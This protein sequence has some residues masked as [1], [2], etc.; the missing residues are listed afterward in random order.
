MN[1][2]PGTRAVRALLTATLALLLVPGAARAAD[3][4]VVPIS[5]GSRTPGPLPQGDK[6]ELSLEQAIRLALQ[7]TLDL[8]VVSLN[9]EKAAFGIGSAK[10]FFDPLVEI[11]A[12]ANRTLSPS[13]SRISAT[14]TKNQNANLTFGGNVETGGSYTLG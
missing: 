8:D 5:S 12:N 9:Y 14:D 1:L 2:P 10:G 11:D 3:P 4:V 13:F 6:I 7:N